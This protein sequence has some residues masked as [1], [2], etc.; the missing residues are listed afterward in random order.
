MLTRKLWIILLGV[1][2][3]LYGLAVL[4]PTLNF[5]GFAVVMAIL[6]IIAGILLLMDR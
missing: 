5:Q 3:I 4:I 6:A 2:L 1:W